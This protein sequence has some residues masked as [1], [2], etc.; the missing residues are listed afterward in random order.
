MLS[1]FPEITS[2]EEFIRLRLSEDSAERER[3]A[4]ATMPLPVWEQLVR[5][6]PDM[7]FWAA[8]NRS[9]PPQILARLVRDDDWRV[10]SRV[11]SRR[12]CP[13]HLLEELAGDPH[14]GVRNTVATHRHSPRSAVVRLMD[15]PWVVIA[16]AARSRIANWP[17]TEPEEA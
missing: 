4:W 7:R 16:E 6:H 14:D 11:S 2:V 15:D 12:D 9:C 3:S 10:R 5:E 8:H 17:E 1:R 13:A